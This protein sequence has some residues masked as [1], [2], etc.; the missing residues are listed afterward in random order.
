MLQS[1]WSY[2]LYIQLKLFVILTWSAAH[3]AV[4]WPC[5]NAGASASLKAPDAVLQLHFGCESAFFG[6]AFWRAMGQAR[7]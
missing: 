1:C 4:L 6:A 3:D 2:R 7:C 5:S